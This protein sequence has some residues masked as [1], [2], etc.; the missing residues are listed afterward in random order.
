MTAVPPR[1]S[2]TFDQPAAPA[3]VFGELADEFESLLWRGQD[4]SLED[5]VDRAPPPLR[6][7]LREELRAIAAEIRAAGRRPPGGPV[8][9]LGEYELLEPLGQ[10]GMGA[11]YRAR[12]RRLGQTVALKQIRP[13]KPLGPETRE[14]FER[15][16]RI[17]GRLQHPHVVEALYAGEESGALF[18][19][20]R[21]VEGTDLQRLVERR[22]PLAVD[23]TCALARQAALGLEY[24]AGQGLVHRDV[25]PSNLLLAWPAGDAAAGPVV[26]ILD[27]GLARLSEP[28]VDLTRSG[29]TLGTPDYLA[30]EQARDAARAGITADLYSL[31]C[32]LF[33]LLTG[34]PPFAHRPGVYDKLRAHAEEAP[35][36]V[37]A[38]RPGVP[39]ALADLLG[40]LLAKDPAARPR[41]PAEV[42]AALEPLAAGADLWA[43]RPQPGAP[44]PHIAAETTA[45]GVP[46]I[47][48]PAAAGG[49]PTSSPAPTPPAHGRRRA[50]PWA[51]GGVA[52]AGLAVALALVLGRKDSPETDTKP[53]APPQSLITSFQVTHYARQPDGKLVLR[54]GLLGERSF[55]VRCNDQVRLHVELGRPAPLYLL[56]FDAAG[57]EKLLW[58][59]KETEPPPA[60]ARLNYPVEEDNGW[61]L[62]D[63]PRGGLQVFA[64]VIGEGPL[65]AYVRWKARR[66]ALSWERIAVSGREE[67]VWRGNGRSLADYFPANRGKK[68][69]LGAQG[70][71]SRLAR[72]L[73]QAPG[74]AEV[75]LVA[76]PVWPR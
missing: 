41:Q 40:R 26:K 53:A 23:Q 44:T 49:G 17:V 22:G 51:A 13:D 14:R 61:T 54:R 75:S 31:G 21:Y 60:R 8:A 47:T 20:M 64:V 24:V 3:S 63:E 76:F 34:R 2:G 72:A 11:V 7:A 71:L 15:E 30:P 46:L 62:D 5:F 48:P 18:L 74:V 35:P 42:A 10:G 69:D 55:A 4:P 16:I 27:L 37:R 33:F 19:V 70:T 38:L 43:L 12:H 58:P 9:R 73:R 45:Q 32:V 66:P 28:D 29:A 59:E 50:W 67:V 65:P 52:A 56:E 36:D 57:H 1:A 68:E 25:K 39:A 6:E